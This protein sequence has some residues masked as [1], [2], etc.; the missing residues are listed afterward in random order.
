MAD[1]KKP[2]HELVA[3]TLIAQLEQGTAPWQRCW[4][5]PA[6]GLTEGL[7]TNPVSGKRYRGINTLHVLAQTRDDPRWLTY[8]QAESLGAQV[9]KGERGTMIQFWKFDEERA[10][11]DAPGNT[12][13][14]RTKLERPRCFHAIVFN[15]E[16][17][18][19]LPP[20]APRPAP[21]WEPVQRA[22]DLL[23]RSGAIIRHSPN[24]GAFYRP[25]TD[26]ITL[27]SQERFD[28]AASYYATALHELGHW[29]GHSSRLDR[30]LSHPFGSEGYAKEELRAEIASL[31]V[32]QELGIGHDGGSHAAYV[33]SWIKILRDD[34]LEIF[35]AAADAEKIT[36]YV[37]ALEQTQALVPA[38][39]VAEIAQTGHDPSAELGAVIQARI[40]F[41]DT[42]PDSERRIQTARAFEECALQTLGLALPADWTG[43]TQVAKTSVDAV[44]YAVL[45]NTG[46][47]TL[48]AGRYKT[49]AVYPTESEARAVEDRLLAI[50]ASSEPNGL[51]RAVKLA[52][53]EEAQLKRSHDTAPEALAAAVDARKRAEFAAIIGAP[54]FQKTAERFASAPKTIDPPQP[55]SEPAPQPTPE[56]SLVP[57]R[58]LQVPFKDK[59]DAK[60]LGARWDRQAQ[61]WYVPDGLDPARFSRWAG[62]AVG[63]FGDTEGTAAEPMPAAPQRQ[64]LAVPFDDHLAAKAAGGLW[65]KSAKSWYVGPRADP[66]KLAQW[67]PEK[68]AAEQGPA[69]N[70]RDEFAE[71]L[72]KIGA[73][74]DG[75]HPIMDGA[76]HRIFVEGDKPKERSGFYVGH[77]DGHPAGFMQNNRTGQKYTWKSKGYVLDPAEKARIHAEAAQKLAAREAEQKA[78]WLNT[79]QRLRDSMAKLVPIAT[80]TPYMQAKGISPSFGVLT[81]GAGQT[82]YVPAFDAQGTLWTMQYIQPDGVKRYAKDS[83]KEGCFHPIGGFA[84]L[85]GAPALVVAEGYSTAASL[86]AAVGFATVAAFDAGNLLPVVQAL[87]AEFAGKPIIVCGDD[88]IP[89]VLQ[90][91]GN[92]G[93]VDAK[94]AAAAVGG[95][96]VFPSFA[97]GEQD[98]DPSRFTDFNDLAHHSA[99]GGEGLR[100]Q[101]AQVL[102]ELAPRRAQAEGRAKAATNV[103]QLRTKRRG[104]SL[105]IA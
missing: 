84:A 73:V 86:S 92:R 19:G 22:H 1:E 82:T 7:P 50:A 105:S 47:P 89:L 59:E 53:I 56:P 98:S 41:L 64:Y 88:D 75:E 100:R 97:P 48:Q 10:Q 80:P 67:A 71:E 69:M 32:G 20:I 4:R 96:A 54:E 30:D 62:G 49:V 42:V 43:D 3:E 31:I 91:K 87:H 77:L 11:T 12:V 23:H 52:R 68:V 39:P 21:D 65:D 36:S 15:A 61:A 26:T 45:V 76:K 58:Y 99:V 78:A 13:Q 104:K 81:D 55:P 74:V 57:R 18:D 2:F 101:L 95:V 17:I 28:D 37:L 66:E 85:V 34:P 33:K 102:A 79:A 40:D 60:Q 25:S 70:P 14:A 94:A 72:R 103:V 6:G 29:S 16:Q 27:P 90:G 63:R 35:R 93:V 38:L 9:R 83:R 46:G 44:A 5:D 8:K 51:E 24:E